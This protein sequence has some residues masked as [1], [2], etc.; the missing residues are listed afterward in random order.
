MGKRFHILTFGCQMNANDSAWLARALAAGGHVPVPREEADLHILNTCSVRAKPENKVYTE[1]GRIRLL[2]RKHPE[3]EILA[4]VG[5]CVAQQLGEKLFARSRE[6][7]LLFGADGLTAAPEA[8]E[9]L[10]RHPDQ[11]LALLDFSPGYPERRT[12][13]GAEE[14]VALVNI[15][16][17]CDNFCAYCIVPLTRGRQKSRQSADVLKECRARIAGGAREIT[18]L[19]QN[20]NSFGQDS[21]GDG[22]SFTGLLE[23]V[24]ALPGLARLGFMTSHP[25]NMPPELIQAFGRLP[26]LA[27][28]LHLPLQSGSDRILR[29]MGRGYTRDAY[30]KIL[31]SLRRVR[32][33]IQI[34][35]D[36]ITGFPG[37]SEN[38]FRKTLE[39]MREADFCASFSF[40]YSDRPGTKAGALPDK[41]PAA[42]ALERLAR[43]QDWQNQNSR[44]ILAAR[45]G[46]KAWVLL[47][48]PS[49]KE[50]FPENNP[51]G[52]ADSAQ[53]KRR[54]WHGREEHG[55]SVNLLI[56]DS[57]RPAPGDLLEA[58]ITGHGRHTLKAA[59]SKSC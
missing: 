48:G 35:T 5:G 16:Q 50:P 36:I 59:L 42:L 55:F 19:G 25:K 56:P 27:P 52:A 46:Q 54:S 30:M 4:C 31:G 41:V 10:F 18:L 44:R 9:H 51:A 53:G 2:A 45:H 3:R 6:L 47:E 28:R 26:A 49:L 21:Q 11:K 17:G 38:D 34:S 24:S 20:V 58:V 1:L 43:L 22:T 8:I 23:Q 7:R 14:P 15:M 39:I 29:A 13:P 32:P 40:A 33:D 57:L 37:E 12:F